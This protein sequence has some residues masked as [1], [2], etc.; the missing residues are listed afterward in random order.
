MKNALIILGFLVYSLVLFLITNPWML[1]GIFILELITSLLV[2]NLREAWLFLLKNSGFVIFVT[3]C[4]LWLASWSQAVLVGAR[5]GL[6]IM[7]AY[8][9]SR[10][11]ST[12]ELA[13]G[14]ATLCMPLKLLGVDITEL[15]LSLTVALTF[16]PLFAREARQL[17]TNLKLKGY[18]WKNFWRQP[19]IY[20]TGFL[21]QL[22]GHIEATEKALRLKGYD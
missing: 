3:L 8:T 17:R 14:I 7:A 21:E 4:N 1:I 9:I 19:Q 15:T 5:L 13:S 12:R 10:R 16:V 2:S 20:V 6:A 22:F 11:L 18:G